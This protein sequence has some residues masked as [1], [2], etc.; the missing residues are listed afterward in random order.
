MIFTLICKKRET[1]DNRKWINYSMCKGKVWYNVKFVKEC[2]APQLHKIMDNVER[3]FIKLELTDKYDIVYKSN[4]SRILFV[5]SY[6]DLTDDELKAAIAAETKKIEDYRKAK[7]KVRIEFLSD[8]SED[9]P[10]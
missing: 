8:G 5:E 2:A 1:E 4:N 3:A 9:I 10:F 7:E 6:S